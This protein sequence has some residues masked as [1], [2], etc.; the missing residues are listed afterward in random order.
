MAAALA[1]ALLATADLHPDGEDPAATVPDAVLLP[2]FPSSASA[3]PE[4]TMLN[5]IGV[6]KFELGAE[7]NLHFA[8]HIAIF[9]NGPHTYA[10]IAMLADYSIQILNLTDPLDPR[11][12]SEVVNSID[13]QLGFPNGVAIFENGSRTYGAVTLEGDDG[14]QILNLT[15]P[16]N[17]R[18]LGVIFDND[19]YTLDKPYAA[20]I[21]QNSSHTFAAV[22]GEKKNGVQ[23]LDLTDPSNPRAVA[24]IND[25]ADRRLLGARGIAVFENGTGTYAAVS[26]HDNDGVQILDLTDPSNPR[27]A[28]HINGSRPLEFN[29]PADIAIFKNGSRTYAAVSMFKENG[30]RILNLT[31]PF[32]PRNVASIF[33]HENFG[34]YNL[35]AAESLAVF[36]NGSRT[37]AAVVGHDN[38]GIQMLDLTDPTDPQAVG[39]IRDDDDLALYHPHGMAV[40]RDAG[41]IYIAVSSAQ[42]NAIQILELV[43]AVVDETDPVI[44]LNG[45]SRITVPE[46][47]AY[48]DQEATCWDEVDGDLTS[49]ITADTSDVDASTPGIYEVTYTCRDA[50]L[51]SATETR[52]VT[53]SDET[54]PV[55]TL[56]GE[57]RIT[58][59]ED[60]AYVDQEATCWDEVDGDLTS[61]ITADTSDVDAS[62]PGIY[63]VTYTCRDAALNSATETRTVT[64]S[65]ETDPVITLNGESRITVPEDTAYVDQGATCWDEVDGDLTSDI[66]AD[67]SDVDASTPGIYEVTYTCRDAALN[68]ATETRTVTVSDETDPVITLNGESRITVPE[69]TAYVDQGATCWDEVDGDLTSDITADTSDVDASTPGIY[70]VT[71]TCRDAAL[72]SATETRTVTVSDETDPVITLNGE[73]RITV[74]EDTAYV[75][76]GATCWDEVD[77]DLTS[78][79]TADTSDVDASTPGIYEVTYTCRDAALNSATE[80]RTVTVSDETDPVITLNGESR[81]TVPEDTAYVDQ[82]ATCWDEVDGDLTSDITADTSDVDASTPGIYEVTY[83]CRDAALNSATETRTVT[84]SDETD[85]VITLNGESRITVPEDTAYVDQG[86]T[87]WD[88]VDGDLTSDIT[89][90]TSD[91]DASTPGIYEVTY[92]CRDAA[93]NSA[94]ETRTVTVSDETDPVIT[95]NGANPLD[96]PVGSSYVSPGSACLDETDGD[97]IARITTDSS[98]VVTSASG[99]YLVFYTCTDDAG[100]TAAATRTVTV[101]EIDTTGPKPT[102]FSAVVFPSNADSADF[103]TNFGE[104]IN[105]DTFN[106]GDITVVGGNVTLGPT[107]YSNNQI[108]HFTVTPAADGSLSIY[109]PF[110]VLN[111]TAGNPN[112]AS[113]TFT[114]TFDR[115]PP[116]LVTGQATMHLGETYINQGVTC[117][118]GIDKDPEILAIDTID[119]SIPGTYNVAYSCTDDAGNVAIAD[120]T[121]IVLDYVLQPPPPQRPEQ[122]P[123]PSQQESQPERDPDSTPS[124]NGIQQEQSARSSGG[125]GGGGGGG[126]PEEIITDVRIYSVSWDCAAGAVSA[127]V[128]PDTDSAHGTHEDQ[129]GRREARQRVRLGPAGQPHVHG[130]DVGRRPVRRGRGQPC[131]RGRPGDNQDR[132]LQGVLGKRN[133]RQV[134]AAGAGA[135]IRTARNGA[136]T[137]AGDLQGR[138]RAGRA[139]RLAPSL[140]LPG[141]I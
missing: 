38:H 80:T 110:N 134:R 97:L 127:T 9:K 34:T 43:E 82:G 131:V 45:E 11:S 95:L 89:A 49:D 13:L 37:Y 57:S 128:G 67:T 47:T 117:T 29:G 124:G 27:A 74:P 53:V 122:S 55:I 48:V 88:E 23:I 51:N 41:R 77:G 81:I 70:E 139:R 32:N 116:V 105:V 15:D 96:I 106:G 129:L 12:V 60:T 58:V 68:S 121:V 137:A 42:E 16:A 5:L 113:E 22:T 65:D 76:Q 2:V 84:V 72:N 107:H 30:V 69:D 8:D 136:G 98:G 71:Y 18:A 138:A 14:V 17:P 35:R 21:F 28:G 115:R 103:S 26:G 54:D 94:T 50:A 93:L 64:V 20:A 111:D 75:D 52:T 87:C 99:E 6:A 24:S 109:I 4:P 118:D 135:W 36:K 126:A 19:T 119:T 85:P 100:N 141:N 61:D 39:G 66:T 104:P 7:T 1:V 102:I 73:S 108:F 91:V 92:T 31:D 132:K 86:A 133:D 33:E 44:T 112:R 62:T 130:R 78:D 114:A 63:E 59:P 125:G 25:T 90:D 123:P 3:T 40:F 120:H 79:I 10:T 140:P 56:N 46:D 83:T 101:S